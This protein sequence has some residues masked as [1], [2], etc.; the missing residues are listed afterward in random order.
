MSRRRVA[1]HPLVFPSVSGEGSTSSTEASTASADAILQPTSPGTVSA[2]PP[3]PTSLAVPTPSRSFTASAPPA[4]RTDST[5]SLQSCPT[6]HK[7]GFP[8]VKMW[9]G[10]PTIQLC[11]CG[12]VW[13][14]AT[15]SPFCNEKKCKR[16]TASMQVECHFG[17]FGYSCAGCKSFAPFSKWDTR[18]V[19]KKK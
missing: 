7:S 4:I 16:R 11:V 5:S 14:P 3:T 17:V 2:P 6:C 9:P 12:L 1:V 15:Q 13:R 10:H 18:G 19:K 8:S